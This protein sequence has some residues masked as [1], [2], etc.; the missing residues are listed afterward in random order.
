[1]RARP[2]GPSPRP[3][4]PWQV[5]QVVV[6]VASPIWTDSWERGEGVAFT[7]VGNSYAGRECVEDGGAT[8]GHDDDRNAEVRT[9]F[10]AYWSIADHIGDEVGE[11]RNEDQSAECDHGRLSGWSDEV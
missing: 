4:S 9:N 11:A 2:A 3:V 5:A 10:E 6:Y 8:D 7:F 1:M